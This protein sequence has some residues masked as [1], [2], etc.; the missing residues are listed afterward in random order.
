MLQAIEAIIEQDGSVRLLEPIHPA[1]SM[2]AVITLLGPLQIK[3]NKPSALSLLE[4]RHDKEAE[5]PISCLDLML[6]YVG[7]LDGPEDLS[8]NKKY[9]EGL[10]T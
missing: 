8:T 5:R 9:L 4:S 2:R 6:P 1:T 3:A 10:G 7:I